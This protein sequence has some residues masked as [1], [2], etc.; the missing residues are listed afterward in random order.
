[1]NSYFLYFVFEQYYS[2]NKLYGDTTGQLH[3]GQ[4]KCNIGGHYFEKEKS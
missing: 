2:H 1:M 3:A 4:A